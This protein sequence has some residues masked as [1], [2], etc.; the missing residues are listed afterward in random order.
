MM[1]TLLIFAFGFIAGAIMIPVIK[2][3]NN[4]PKRT[5]K[6]DVIKPENMEEISD[7]D[8]KAFTQVYFEKAMHAIQSEEDWKVKVDNS[9]IE[10]YKSV[11]SDDGR[12]QYVK[13]SA[14]YDFD[15]DG[16]KKF[17][18]R[19]SINVE[20]S[21]GTYGNDYRIYGDPTPEIKSFFYKNYMAW[22]NEVNEKK[23]QEI[24]KKLESFKGILGK[25]VDRDMKLDQLLGETE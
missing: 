23:K 25:S 13:V 12:S 5:V 9:D 11:K 14:R 1:N 6:P 8:E 19:H 20:G 7:F 18:I 4:R 24:S 15:K 22:K 21:N 3:L 10:F 16:N 2:Y 17:N